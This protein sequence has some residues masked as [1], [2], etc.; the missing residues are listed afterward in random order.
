V[1]QKD[2]K[3]SELL[4]VNAAGGFPQPIYETL[5]QDR[6]LLLAIA[7]QLLDE[8]F[9]SSL[10]ERLLEAVGLTCAR[11]MKRGRVKKQRLSISWISMVRYPL[12]DL[13]I[14]QAALITNF[15]TCAKFMRR[16]ARHKS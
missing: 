2:Q 1:S 16:R 8:H 6:A 9:P 10:H 7:Q 4:R 13:Q 15:S 12:G 11:R 14:R 5:A 3:K